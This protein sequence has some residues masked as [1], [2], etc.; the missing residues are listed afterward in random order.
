MSLKVPV[1]NRSI[2]L[3]T[4]DGTLTHGQVNIASEAQPMDRPSD[5]LI[6][7]QS[8]FLLVSQASIE[9]ESVEAILI[10]KHHIVWAIP[11]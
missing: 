6:R 4:V 10:N 7:G 11:E 2:K 3:K 5:Y 1:N 9:G 8:P